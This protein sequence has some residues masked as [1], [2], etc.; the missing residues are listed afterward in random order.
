MTITHYGPRGQMAN[1]RYVDVQT[2]P[3]FPC[4]STITH[5]QRTAEKIIIRKN[6]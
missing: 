6:K 3:L 5:K 2:N 4:F 1:V